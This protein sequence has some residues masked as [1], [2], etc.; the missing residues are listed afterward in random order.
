MDKKERFDFV[1]PCGIDCGTC[2]LNI[3]RDNPVLTKYLIGRGIPENRIPCDGCRNIE[4]KCPVISGTCATYSCI[5]EKNHNF[6]F[7]CSDFPCNKLNPAADRADVLPHNTK[8]FNLCTIQKKGVE[9]F[10]K[11][12]GEIKQRYYKGKMEVGSGPQLSST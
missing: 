9:E 12:S 7:E 11:R 3:C 2:E 6:C 1:A 4:G 5:T 8:V 10:V